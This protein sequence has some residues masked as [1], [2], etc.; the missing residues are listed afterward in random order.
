M[1]SRTLFP[2]LLVLVL[3]LSACGPKTDP[4]TGSRSVPTTVPT[5]SATNVPTTAPTPTPT[6]T[7][8]PTD[9]A[10]PT[11]T[12]TATYTATPT[13]TPTPTLTA[14]PTVTPTATLTSMPSRTPTRTPIPTRTPVPTNTPV[15]RPTLPVTIPGLSAWDVTGNMRQRGFTCGAVWYG[16][17]GL[18]NWDCESSTG[19][20]LLAS[21]L[22][23]HVTAEDVDRLQS[24]DAV[25]MQLASPDDK[26]AGDFLGFVA[27]MPYRGSEPTRARDWVKANLVKGGTTVIGGVRFSLFGPAT[28]RTLQ[29]VAAGLPE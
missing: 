14:T 20:G 4:S 11:L 18:M 28:G 3:L 22:K 17:T 12:P 2:V 10:T 8:T 26:L 24:I 13:A 21:T 19:T 7:I 6:A 9:T 23:V 5:A 16:A 15:P 29:M 25:A 1:F 27:T